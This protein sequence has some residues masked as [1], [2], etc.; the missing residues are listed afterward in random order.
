MASISIP[1][2]RIID[3]EEAVRASE[4]FTLRVAGIPSICYNSAEDFLARDDFER[5]GCI[6][7]D[8]RMTG[9]SG[10]EL[11]QEMLA[12]KIDLP[13]IFLSGHGDI[14]MA[15]TALQKGAKE[16][17][18]KPLAPEKLRE[19]VKRL[20]AANLVEREKKLAIAQKRK[21]FETLTK[22]EALI[23][24]YVAKDLLNKEIAAELDIQEHTVKIHRGNACRKLNLRSAL[25]IHK[26]LQEIGELETN[27]SV[28]D[29]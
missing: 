12:R 4:S 15:V 29:F 19:V 22:R 5:P 26:F 27:L 16:F 8:I 3:D 14:N 10:L 7:L 18:E 21:L 11:Q 28:G 20:I 9:I 1:I 24:R 6:I 2:V 23:L 13:I 17:Y 25:E